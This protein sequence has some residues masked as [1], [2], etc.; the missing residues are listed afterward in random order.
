ML[1]DNIHFYFLNFYKSYLHQCKQTTYVLKKY[2][3]YILEFTRAMICFYKIKA[4]AIL[5]YFLK[6]NFFRKKYLQL[7]ETC[8]IIVIDKKLSE[9]NIFSALYF[10]QNNLYEQ[11][12]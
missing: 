3:I 6:K 8:Y 4:I 9:K 5:I 11:V 1:F 7:V 12:M 10:T 2:I